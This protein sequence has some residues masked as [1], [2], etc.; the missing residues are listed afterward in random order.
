MAYLSDKV[1]GTNIVRDIR[2]RAMRPVLVIGSDTF[3]RA[4]LSGVTCFNFVAAANLS[5]AIAPLKIKNTRDLFQHVSPAALALPH[6]GSI[7]LSVLGAA[8][9]AKKL[10]GANP[11]EAW[12]LQ[13]AAAD[14]KR[15]LTTF[16][17]VKAR[18]AKERRQEA[19]TKKRRKR[20]RRDEAHQLRLDRFAASQGVETP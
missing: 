15:P 12:M 19:K 5:D 3:T 10:G 2:Q 9:E 16:H 13:H 6:V 11:L 20:Q 7:A 17:T 4:D 1:L 8:F 18:E 14:A